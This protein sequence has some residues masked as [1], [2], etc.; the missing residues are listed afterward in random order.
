MRGSMV[1]WRRKRSDAGLR[2]KI[3]NRYGSTISVSG[4]LPSSFLLDE[5][6]LPARRLVFSI[7]LVFRRWCEL[8]RK[9]SSESNNSESLYVLPDEFLHQS[10]AQLERPSVCVNTGIYH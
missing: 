10:A 9:L 5:L 7:C 1:S 2:N 8:G 6:L 4:G 3:Q